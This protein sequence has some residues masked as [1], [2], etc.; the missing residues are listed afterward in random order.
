MGKES[1]PG[2][3]D[4]EAAKL[5]HRGGS[6]ALHAAVIVS[7]EALTNLPAEFSTA[8]WG[9]LLFTAY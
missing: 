3:L 9:I 7:V 5:F 4:S 8:A 1:A 2:A 6:T